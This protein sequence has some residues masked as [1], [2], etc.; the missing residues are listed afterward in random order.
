[1]SSTAISAVVY[2]RNDNH[3]YNYSKRV[4]LSLNS[5]AE[6][7]DIGDEIIF[8]DWNSPEGY[9]PLLVS[10]AD[11]LSTRAINL[12]K[13]IVVPGAIHSVVVPSSAKRSIVEPHARNVGIRRAQ[14]ESQWI[15]STNTDIVFV[16]KTPNWRKPL[17][18]TGHAYFACPRYELPEY[19]WESLPRTQPL[20]TRSLIASFSAAYL[21]ERAV[22]SHEYCLYDAPGDFQLARRDV[23]LEIGGFDESMIF[24]WHVDSNFGKR[25]WLETGGVHSISDSLAIYHC[26]HS[27][28]PTQYQTLKAPSNDPQRFVDSVGFGEHKLAA[29]DWGLPNEPLENI[30]LRDLLKQRSGHFGYRA[31]LERKSNVSLKTVSRLRPDDAHSGLTVNE[32]LPFVLDSILSSDPPPSVLYLG[33]R[34]EFLGVL[35]GLK[36]QDQIRSLSHSLALGGANTPID[37]V[38]VDL[39]PSRGVKYLEDHREVRFAPED[40][41]GLI[42]VLDQLQA[43]YREGEQWDVIDKNTKWVFINAEENV[44]WG[45][46]SGAFHLVPSQFYSRV[47]RGIPKSHRSGIAETLSRTLGTALDHLADMTREQSM[48]SSSQVA[49]KRQRDRGKPAPSWFDL[50]R[51]RQSLRS[52][53]GAVRRS[54]NRG[55]AVPV[56]LATYEV[57]QEGLEVESHAP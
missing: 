27:R 43:L 35:A 51:V 47:S 11:T 21:L 48:T 6:I 13:V 4:S 56:T 34:L 44:F 32:N 31:V 3:G 5:L 15:L 10:I 39:T 41:V 12:T 26:N 55:V 18:E 8:V 7:L 52:Q 42:Q 25:L 36:H 20:Q 49:A 28:I 17:T 1:M 53:L 19:F 16:P 40:A 33:V 37:L 54:L 9:P 57:E 24:G 23:V 38:I 2:G 22:E 50:R 14:P 46:V 30:A 29:N 45:C